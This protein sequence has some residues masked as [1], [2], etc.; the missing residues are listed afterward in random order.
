M[1]PPRVPDGEQERLADLFACVV[2][3]T[4]AE[5]EFDDA[6]RVAAWVAGTPIAL[7]SLVDGSRQWFKARVGLDATETPRDVS[8][9]GHVVASDRTLIVPDAH[10]DERFADNP[11]VTG[12]P[13]VRFY[14]G[15]ALH[16]RSGHVL[17]TLCVIDHVPRELDAQTILMLEAQARQV[18]GLLELRRRVREHEQAQGALT[19]AL[20]ERDDARRSEARWFELNLDML[21]IA[22]FEGMFTRLNPAWSAVLGYELDELL[23]RPFIEF[24]H[25]EDRDRTN[26]E[27]AHLGGGGVTIEFENRYRHKDGTWRWLLWA[28]TSDPEVGEIYAVA[29]DITERKRLDVMKDEFISTVSHELRTP[30]TSIRGS[31]GLVTGGVLGEVPDEVRSVLKIAEDNSVRLGRLVN[32][33]LDMEKLGAGRLQ[34]DRRQLP[35]AELLQAACEANAG[36][37]ARHSAT[38]DLTPSPPFMVLADRH[39]LAQVLDNLLSNACKFSPPG[40]RVTLRA[41]PWEDGMIRVFVTDEGPGIPPEFQ[42]HVFDRFEQADGSTSAVAGG[43]GLGLAIA[44]SIVE[45]HGGRI[46]FSSRVGRG[47]TFWFELAEERSSAQQLGA[48]L[49]PPPPGAAHVLVCEDDP[50]VASIVG[51]MVRARGYRVT[52]VRSAEEAWEVLQAVRV[53]AMTLDLHLPG[54]DGLTFLQQLRA[55]ERFADLPVIVV[56]GT[57]SE[58]LGPVRPSALG[59]T[60]W[61]RKPVDERRLLRALDGVRAQRGGA[62]RV[63]HIDDDPVTRRVLTAVAPGLD[64]VT[65]ATVAEARAKLKEGPW[66]G[67]VLD[68]GL[69]DGDGLD[70]LPEIKSQ[71]PTPSVVIFS[72]REVD[73]EHVDGV[74]AALAKSVRDEGDVVETLRE[75]LGRSRG[76]PPRG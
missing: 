12:P 41:E 69:P 20:A 33:L 14:A 55:D 17:G 38:I 49:P 43:T 57:G 53:D 74:A 9:C 24:V 6:A 59:L 34:L 23:S 70:L 40:G 44:R 25:P 48:T 47:T 66:H 67:V 35:L 8:F 42:P 19:D 56:T 73:A 76:R 54:V 15:A 45:L 30:L 72:G 28:G 58:G 32:D 18:A 64:V 62:T 37:A 11:L 29:R 60:D 26:A 3:D 52:E 51:L 31:L 13:H 5:P 10:A 1:K 68:L 61:L 75:L 63:L 2:L 36:Y 46:G 65:A 27:A 7:V 39:R 50:D 71:R 22:N 21:C 16:S 4:Q